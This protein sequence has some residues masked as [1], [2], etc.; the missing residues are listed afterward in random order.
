MD[1][2]D[3]IKPKWIECT[4]YDQIGPNGPNKIEVDQSE[5]SWP[6]WIKVGLIRLNR[7]C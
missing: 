2:I 7:N 6:N 4:E 5:Q 1:K 3:W